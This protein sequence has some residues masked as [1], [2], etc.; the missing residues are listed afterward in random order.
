VPTR[1]MDKPKVPAQSS[2]EEDDLDSMLKKLE[3]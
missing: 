3:M 1:V 2:T